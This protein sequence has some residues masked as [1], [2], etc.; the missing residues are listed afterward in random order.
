MR[1]R[2]SLTH[3]L[4]HAL[5]RLVKW[6]ERGMCSCQPV[7]DDFYVCPRCEAVEVLKRAKEVLQ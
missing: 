5:A 1:D 2:T 4:Y 6:T 7:A 3:E